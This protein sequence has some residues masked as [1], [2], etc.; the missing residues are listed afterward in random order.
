M[1][2]KRRYLSNTIG[3]S[4]YNGGVLPTVTVTPYGN[5]GSRSIYDADNIDDIARGLAYERMNVNPSNVIS[6]SYT[7]DN[8]LHRPSRSGKPNTSAIIND[9]NTGLAYERLIRP[10]TTFNR[11]IRIRRRY[12]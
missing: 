10:G 9:I 11:G 6:T 1:T 4:P 7:D 12:R 8:T 3:Y 2:R 5:V